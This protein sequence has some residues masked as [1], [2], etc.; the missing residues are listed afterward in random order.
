MRKIAVPT[1]NGDLCPH[2]GHCQKFAVLTVE[3]NKV[4]QEDFLEP[5]AHQPG[6][7]PRWLQQLGVSEVIAGGMGQKA[8]DIFKMHGIKVHMGVDSKPA[9]QVVAELINNEL[10]TGSN[11]CD[12]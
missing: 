12:H 8:Q 7:Y 10:V 1:I 4:V 3:D 6:I 9:R 2:F 11:K 5:P